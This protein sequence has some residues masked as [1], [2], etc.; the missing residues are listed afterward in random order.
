MIHTDGRRTI[1]NAPAKHHKPA[2]GGYPGEVLP[3]SGTCPH[4]GLRIP[5][6]SCIACLERL[7]RIGAA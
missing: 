7:Y 1:A 3:S 4:T 6:C 5:E 2:H